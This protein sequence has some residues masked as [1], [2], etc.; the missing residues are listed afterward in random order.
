MRCPWPY[1]DEGSGDR[2][3]SNEPSGVGRALGRELA[4][5]ADVEAAKDPGAPERCRDCAFRLGTRPNGCATTV[6]DA[7]K[8]A[9]EGEA[10]YCHLGVADGEEPKR[11]C[12]GWSLLRRATDR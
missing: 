4:R 9:V 11:P 2:L 8:C 3:V 7:L 5:L 1:S 6:M 12:A 10:F